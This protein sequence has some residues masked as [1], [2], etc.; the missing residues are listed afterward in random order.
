MKVAWRIWWARREDGEGELE[1]EVGRMEVRRV[2]V[3]SLGAIMRVGV[4]QWRA[5]GCD[6]WVVERA[7]IASDVENE[8]RGWDNPS[9][10]RRQA[11]RCSLSRRVGLLVS[12]VLKVKNLVRFTASVHRANAYRSRYQSRCCTYRSLGVMSEDNKLRK[13]FPGHWKHIHRTKMIS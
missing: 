13:N 11:R 1:E 12:L 9:G 7:T 6:L 8:C 5:T 10:A 3:G 4:A 2:V